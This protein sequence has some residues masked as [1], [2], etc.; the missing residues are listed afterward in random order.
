MRLLSVAT[1]TLSAAAGRAAEPTRCL[2]A[3]A[4]LLASGGLYATHVLP[5]ET[6][7]ARLAGDAG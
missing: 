7:G 5:V 4:L 6:A 2:L 3:I 1:L